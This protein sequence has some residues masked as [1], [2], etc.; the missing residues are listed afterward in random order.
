M[1]KI[2]DPFVTAISDFQAPQASFS[3]NKFL[4]VGDTLALFRPHI[5]QSINQAAI[6]CMLLEKVLK[7]KIDF[8]EWEKQV[9]Q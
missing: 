2:T 5:A 1:D 8:S 3:A 6:D 4:L 9:T 7:G